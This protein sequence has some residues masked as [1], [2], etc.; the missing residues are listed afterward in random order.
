M[1]VQKFVWSLAIT[2]YIIVGINF[3]EKER[4]KMFGDQYE[5]YK[6]TTPALIPFV[7]F[8]AFGQDKKKKRHNH[9]SL[10]C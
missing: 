5:K 8:C 9:L 7:N 1:T 4:I 3:E 10:K 6:E 2:V